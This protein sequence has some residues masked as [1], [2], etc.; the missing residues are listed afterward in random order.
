GLL[1]DR[2][3][4]LMNSPLAMAILGFASGGRIDREAAAGQTDYARFL[5]T[6]DGPGFAERLRTLLEL[7]DPAV[8]ASQYTLIGSHDTPR[9]RTV[10]AD[11]VAAL[12]LATLLLLTLPGAPAIYY[13]DE[14][15][16]AGGP[17]PG[18]RGAYP[19]EPSAEQ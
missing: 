17:D 8:T 7:H 9:A 18:C 11:D 4:A 19:T 6:L 15:A 12:R 3:D 5:R 1:G 2:C 14:L 13:G 16:L 10:L